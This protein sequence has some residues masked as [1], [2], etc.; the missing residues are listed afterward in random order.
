MLGGMSA[1]LDYMPDAGQSESDNKTNRPC[2][3]LPQQNRQF[4]YVVTDYRPSAQNTSTNHLKGC[5]AVLCE[6][7]AWLSKIEVVDGGIGRMISTLMDAGANT[8]FDIDPAQLMSSFS[9]L[10]RLLFEQ[11]IKDS[12]NDDEEEALFS[13]KF[14]ASASTYAK[15]RPLV[16]IFQGTIRNYSAVLA[17]NVLRHEASSLGTGTKKKRVSR[18]H[19]RFDICSSMAAVSGTCAMLALFASCHSC[20]TTTPYHRDPETVLGSIIHLC[21]DNR[22]QQLGKLSLEELSSEIQ[23]T[24]KSAWIQGAYSPLAM[25]SYS[26]VLLVLFIV[27][28]TIA[29]SQTLLKSKHDDGLWTILE[30]GDWTTLLQSIPVLFM[31]LVSVYSSSLDASI[32]SLSLLAKLSIQPCRASEMDISLADMLGIEVLYHSVR[33]RVPVTA[34]VQ[35]LQVQCGL[36]PIIG[37]LLLLSES[38]PRTSNIT[39]DQELSW[40]GT[41]RITADNLEELT[42]GRDH[43]SH[44]NL[45]QRTMNFTSPENTYKDLVFPRFNLSDSLALPLK[46]EHQLRNCGHTASDFPKQ[47]SR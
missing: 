17:H 27:G 6:P 13:K 38:I 19:A 3:S 12:Q 41:R 7:R 20:R 15:S 16:E 33:L 26:R 2:S 5:A 46:F 10:P 40:F 9:S 8:T 25:R 21:K 11:L 36:L 39:V 34:L 30:S 42:E 28:L 18:L 22:P 47:I 45:L 29:L 14:D 24:R 23:K 44:L 37:S 1:T 43:L 35:I 31:L 32:R 4:M